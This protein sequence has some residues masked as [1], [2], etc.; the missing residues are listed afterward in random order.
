MSVVYLALGANLGDRLAVLD[1]ALEALCT[2][3]VRV[4]ARSPVFETDAVADEPQP[5]YL[6]MVVRADTALAARALLGLCLGVESGLGRMRRRGV[7]NAPRTI[8][9]D[10]LLYDDRVVREPDLEVPHPRMHG[11][12]FVRIPLATVAAPG[13]RHPVTGEPLDVAVP[14][15]GVRCLGDLG[16]SRKGSGAAPSSRSSSRK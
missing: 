1:A 6:N 12:P 11:R 16:A 3:G 15:L 7:R 8:D 13:L 2:G 10:L 4:S 14:D 9:I 5:P